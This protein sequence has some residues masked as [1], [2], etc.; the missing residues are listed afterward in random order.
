[1]MAR[2]EELGCTVL[3]GK[4]DIILDAPKYHIF[5]ST[6]T[7]SIVI[8]YA[9]LYGGESWKP[10]AYAQAIDD[11]SMGIIYDPFYETGWWDDPDDAELAKARATQEVV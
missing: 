9:D 5:G 4:T 2:V 1:M 10:Q 7:S 8:E 6:L 3:Y 11:M